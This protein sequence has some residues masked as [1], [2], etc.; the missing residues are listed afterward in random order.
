MRSMLPAVPASALAP[1][2]APLV[3]PLAAALLAVAPAPAAAEGVAFDDAWQEQG[4]LRLRTNDYGL[5]G[6]AL[7]V[8]SDG[9]FSLLWRPVPEALRGATSASWDWSVTEGVPATDLG[10]RGGD[11]RNLALYFAWT[12][13]ETAA[14]ADPSRAARLLRAPSTRVLVY[15]WGD[16]EAPGT[17]L[18]SPYLPGLRTVLLRPAGTGDA[19]E[20]VDLAA[21]FARAFDGEAP[22]VLVGLGVSADS[23]DTETRI[24]AAVEGLT[25]R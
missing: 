4:F 23:D 3:A 16:D 12:D 8:A 17:V 6:D 19:S 11:D 20:A 7:R 5:E 15:V 14:S 18:D 1:L 22:G 25:L 13:A 2:V 10:V 24:R 9:T 21:D